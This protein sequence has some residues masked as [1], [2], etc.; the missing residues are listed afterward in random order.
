MRI[1]ISL[2]NLRPGKV[3]GIETYIR[4][5]VEWAPQVAAAG[6]EVVFFTHRE[7]RDLV[8]DSCETVMVDCSLLAMDLFRLLEAFTFWR[9]RA[10]ERMIESARVDVMFYTQQTIFPIDCHVPSLLFVADLQYLFHP[11]YFPWSDRQFRLRSYLRSIRR[12]TRIT[13]VSGFSAK[14]IMEQCGVAADRITVIHHGFDPVDAPRDSSI[15]PPSFPYIYYPAASYPHKGHA[16]LFR[17]YAKLFREGKIRQRLLLSGQRNAHWKKLEKIL[18]EE[19]MEGEIVHLGY[20]SYADVITLYQHAEAIVFPSEF[21]GF[22]IPV[23]EAVQF[24]RKIICS[25][26]PTFV[27]L[28]VP[29]EWQI[30][31]EDPD[32]LMRALDQPGPTRLEHAPISWQEAV[33]RTFDLLHSIADGI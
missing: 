30:D 2:L 11:R 14:H 3:G 29:E 17:A 25:R 24:G 27:E 13:T 16:A 10:I 18:D 26:I 7:N 22:G 23:L 12:A 5:V 19:G 33:Q 32:Q 20:V 9:A 15:K 6:D 1:G 21:E 8:P 28:G 31:F 4:K